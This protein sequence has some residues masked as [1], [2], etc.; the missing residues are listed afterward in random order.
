MGKLDLDSKYHR[1]QLSKE[2]LAL[3][4]AFNRENKWESSVAAPND[5]P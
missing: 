1:L 5:C 4:S 3:F 2:F